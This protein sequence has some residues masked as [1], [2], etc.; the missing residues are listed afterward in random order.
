M[1][2]YTSVSV[3]S[4]YKPS[5]NVPF[6]GLNITSK[7]KPVT[8]AIQ[9]VVS[10]GKKVTTKIKNQVRSISNKIPTSKNKKTQKNN[11]KLKAN[12][13]ENNN[14]DYITQLRLKINSF[15]PDKFIKINYKGLVI[16]KSIFAN[17]ISLRDIK[18]YYDILPPIL[19][20]YLNEI[21]I[22]NKIYLTK[23]GYTL[24]FTS[25]NNTQII[26]LLKSLE[27]NN[28]LNTIIH[29]AAHVLDLNFTQGVFCAISNSQTWK[30]AYMQ[31]RAN[32]INKGNKFEHF[33]VSD[34]AHNGAIGHYKKGEFESIFAEDFAESM[35]LY[36]DPKTHNWFVN[37]FSERTKIIE[38][39]LKYGVM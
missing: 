3:G 17:Y 1:K 25:S 37:T 10:T 21:N 20:V 15:I 2:E 29:E 6:G 26:N 38:N 35:M 24:G 8:E 33:F 22:S 23:T 12:N 28:Y 13:D 16:S 7:T 18:R 27:R 36:L 34:Y 5:V 31:D 14:K 32:N 9:T 11:G 4:T 30:K 19:K 39:L